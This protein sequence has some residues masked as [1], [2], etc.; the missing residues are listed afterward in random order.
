MTANHIKHA[1]QF[2]EVLVGGG[3]NFFATMATITN[4]LLV[5]QKIQIA[6]KQRKH[7]CLWVYYS[8]VPTETCLQLSVCVCLVGSPMTVIN[9]LTNV[10]SQKALWLWLCW[11]HRGRCACISISYATGKRD[12]SAK[13][14]SQTSMAVSLS[15]VLT[16]PFSLSLSSPDLSTILQSHPLCILTTCLSV[17]GPAYHPFITTCEPKTQTP[18][19]IERKREREQEEKGETELIRNPQRWV[20]I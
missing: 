20:P 5:L 9:D 12:K 6:D 11:V 17:Y 4:N 7:W 18:L 19:E 16:L 1:S 10:L 2:K 14:C 13:I 3:E 8:A 15:L